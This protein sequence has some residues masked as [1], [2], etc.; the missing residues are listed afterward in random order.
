MRVLLL[1]ALL[2]PTGVRAQPIEQVSETG[3]VQVTL[4]LSPSEPLIGDPLTFE[5]EVRAESGVEV[6][7]PEFGEALD[8]F[9]IVDF[10]PSE[11]LDAQGRTIAR[12]RYTLHASRSGPQSLPPILVEFVDRRPGRDPAPEGE[13]AY[14][15]LTERIDF[16]VGSVLPEDADLEL[17]RARGELGPLLPPGRP[18]W[19]FAGL[20]LLGAAALAPVVLRVWRSYRLR[21]RSRDASEIALAELDALLAGPRP[22]DAREMDLFFVGL[23]GI[24]RRYLEGR[25]G[26]HSPELTTEEFLE[27]MAAAPELNIENTRLLR[28]FLTRADLVKFAHHIP[29]RA[30]VQKSI[31]TAQHFLENT[32]EGA[33]ARNDAGREE[34]HA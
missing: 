14:E 25:F 3:P 28:G 6:L 4:R 11:E 31:E 19:V 26:L 1:L 30:A 7:M 29:D 10:L 18:W 34:L 15:H 24:I 5:L 21:E 32:R 13:D 8:R 22:R 27:V 33:L 12:Q 16:E 9:S 23:S 2:L 17:R 20:A